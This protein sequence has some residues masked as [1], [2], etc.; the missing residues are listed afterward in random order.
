MTCRHQQ[1]LL[2][3]MKGAQLNSRSCHAQQFDGSIITAARIQGVQR[4]R[5]PSPHKL[6]EQLAATTWC[7]QL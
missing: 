1:L 6:C 2:D 4:A 7:F 5:L 3:G